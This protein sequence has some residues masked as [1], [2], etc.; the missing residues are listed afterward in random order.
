M[1]SHKRL[2][3]A[4]ALVDLIRADPA[5]PLDE[6]AEAPRRV[7]PDADL[8]EV[9][10]LMTD[11]D[12]TVVPVV[13]GDEHLVGVITVDDV[14]TYGRLLTGRTLTRAATATRQLMDDGALSTPCLGVTSRPAA[15][16]S[17]AA[18]RA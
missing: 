15:R 18:A 7:R 4:V 1:N 12:L 3:G 14:Q 10:R 9:A 11:F 13:D 16:P 17:R 2:T 5:L 6:I 8:E